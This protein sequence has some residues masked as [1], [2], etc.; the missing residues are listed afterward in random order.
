M[1]VHRV[2]RPVL[3]AHYTIVGYVLAW[4]IFLMFTKYEKDL[5]AKT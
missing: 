4:G 3:H 1:S 2:R 5:R